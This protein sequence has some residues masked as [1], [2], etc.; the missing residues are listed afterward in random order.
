[1]LS[2]VSNCH[3][4]RAIGQRIFAQELGANRLFQLGHSIWCG[5]FG[6]AFCNRFDC[7]GLDM[8]WGVKIWLARGERDH[9]TSR[10]L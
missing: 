6:F 8:V 5:V 7:G 10:C 3:L 2:A 4:R 9:V 1:L